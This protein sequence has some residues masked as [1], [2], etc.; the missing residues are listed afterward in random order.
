LK[1]R[2]T[3]GIFDAGVDSKLQQGVDHRC[4]ILGR[5]QMQEGSADG[6]HRQAK[7]SFVWIQCLQHSFDHLDLVEFDGALQHGEELTFG[8]MHGF[9]YRRLFSSCSRSQRQKK[10][11]Y[12]QN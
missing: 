11:L 2:L 5:G 8:E 1:R 6:I 9:F 7:T 10:Q 4:E 12:R 3:K